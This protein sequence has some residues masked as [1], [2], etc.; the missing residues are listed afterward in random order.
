[1][2]RQKK[3]ASAGPAVLPV[4]EFVI[5]KDVIDALPDAVVVVDSRQIIVQ[6]NRV[7]ARMFGWSPEELIGRDLSVLIPE[8]FRAG[9]VAAVRRFQT[10]DLRALEMTSR[11]EICGLRRDGGEVFIEGTLLKTEIPAAGGGQEVHMAVILRDVSV[12]KQAE[13]QLRLALAE[14]IASSRAKSNFLAT[15]SHELRTPLNAIIGFSELIENETFGPVGDP[16][17]E[18]YIRDIK[19]SGE[20]LLE[21]VSSVLR[22]ARLEADRMEPQPRWVALKPL[23]EAA[24]RQILPAL[25]MRGQSLAVDIDETVEIHAD[26]LLVR[27]IFIN[28]LSNACKF[29]PEGD[30]IAVFQEELGERFAITVLDH[31]E[32]IAPD[33]VATLGHPF[34][35]APERDGTA[36]GMG[37][38]LYIARSYLALHGAALSISSVPGSGTRVRTCWPDSRRRTANPAAGAKLADLPARG[39]AG[40]GACDETALGTCLPCLLADPGQHCSRSALD[41]ATGRVRPANPAGGAQL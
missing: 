27:Q 21:I 14:T 28:L 1:M 9:H 3:A 40:K 39:S 31:G 23:L 12:R 36:G 6:A 17:Y 7:T 18:E 22:A 5:G 24:G 33:T 37:L 35:Q 38:G 8:R 4:T 34:V 2:K 41:P 15:M 30:R 11:S 10:G 29:S 25:E 16:H 32:G 13:R 19:E 26:P 20:H